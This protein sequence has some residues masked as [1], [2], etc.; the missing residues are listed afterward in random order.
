[1]PGGDMLQ[2]FIP[3]NRKV[4]W[5]ISRGRFD[6]MKQQVGRSLLKTEEELRDAIASKKTWLRAPSKSN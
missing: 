1:M 3:P 6:K 2:E 5:T 4:L